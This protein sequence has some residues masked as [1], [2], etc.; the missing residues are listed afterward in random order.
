LCAGEAY[1]HHGG[2]EQEEAHVVPNV[3]E[4]A[5]FQHSAGGVRSG[6]G[7]RLPFRIWK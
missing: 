7:F 1:Y 4:R 5:S 3:R 6:L 2:D